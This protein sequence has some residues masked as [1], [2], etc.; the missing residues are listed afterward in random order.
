MIP[1]SR[2]LVFF[3]SL[4]YFLLVYSLSYPLKKEDT[5]L[6]TSLWKYPSPYKCWMR[7]EASASGGC[8]DGA[9]A[10]GSSVTGCPVWLC[11]SPAVGGLVP[12]INL[13]L[14]KPALW[15][16]RRSPASTPFWTSL[17]TADTP[18]TFPQLVPFPAQWGPFWIPTCI[19]LKRSTTLSAGDNSVSC[20]ISDLRKGESNGFYKK[21]V[22]K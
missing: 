20:V 19:A 5:L 18:S 16:P 11:P 7:P 14:A 4:S 2:S 8:S 9:C 22:N 21:R 13:P 17:A 10:L 12:Q 1:S 3:Y 15:D 6:L